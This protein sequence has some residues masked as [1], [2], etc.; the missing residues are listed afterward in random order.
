[1]M[2]AYIVDDREVDRYTARR[3][4]SKCGRFS[5]VHEA[6]DGRAFLEKLFKDVY[7]VGEKGP[8][9]LM[10]I[11]MPY[12]DGFETVDA[13]RAR[14]IKLGWPDNVVVVMVS[15]SSAANDKARAAD[16]PLVQGYF[17]KPIR[18]GDVDQM[19]RLMDG[20]PLPG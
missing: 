2:Q 20:C 8:L 14:M 19:L 7:P 5:A 13:L 17:E 15:S 18:S 10:D 9:V 4:L 6:E 3:R 16:M 11:S 1:M 12:M